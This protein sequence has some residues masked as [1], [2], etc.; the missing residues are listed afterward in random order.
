M[1][2]SRDVDKANKAQVAEFA[3]ILTSQAH[4]GGKRIPHLKELAES[5]V[6]SWGGV[7]AFAKRIPLEFGNAKPGS[8]QR[9]KLLDATIRLLEIT[10]KLGMTDEAGDLSMVSDADLERKAADIIRRVGNEDE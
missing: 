1:V 5:I 3:T 9:A 4:K 2:R 7:K 10:T 8:M 6:S